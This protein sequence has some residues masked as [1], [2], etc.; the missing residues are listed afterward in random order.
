MHCAPASALAVSIIIHS[1][2]KLKR[3]NRKRMR[4]TPF[5]STPL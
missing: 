1:A 3:K 5:T 2:R 4:G